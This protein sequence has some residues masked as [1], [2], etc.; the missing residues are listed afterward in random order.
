VLHGYVLRLLHER[1]SYQFSNRKRLVTK[2]DRLDAMTIANILLSREAQVGYVAQA[3]VYSYWV[4]VHLQ[5]Q[6]SQEAATYKKEIHGL[7]VVLFPE[8]IQIFTDPFLPGALEVLKAYPS[9]SEIAAAGDEAIIH[10]LEISTQPPTDYDR[11]RIHKL[12]ELAR[13]AVSSGRT[14][15]GQSLRLRF[16]C[17]QLEHTQY[18]FAHLQTEIEQLLI[19]DPQVKG[20]KQI[21]KFGFKT[22]AASHIGWDDVQHKV[23]ADNVITHPNSLSKITIDQERANLFGTT[24][25]EHKLWI[26]YIFDWFGA[27]LEMRLRRYLVGMGIATTVWG[28]GFILSLIIGF[29][30]EYLNTKAVYFFWIGIAWC[31]NALRWLSQVYHIR[32]N[33]VRPCFPVDDAIYKSTVSPF[34][35]KAVRNKR[36]FFSSTILVIPILIYFGAIM[37]GYIKP[38]SSLALGFPSSFPKYWLTGDFLL[39]KWAIIALLLWVAFVEVFTG[40]QLT[41]STAPL[42]DKLSTLPVLPLPSLVSDL[43]QGILNLYLTGALMWS[44]GIV[45]V[46]LLYGTHA[47]VLGI[48]FVI[49]VIGLGVFAYLKPLEAIRRIWQNA[50]NEAIGDTL[51][52]VYTSNTYK[53]SE[54]LKGINEYIQSI[55]NSE[56]GKLNMVQFI[57]FVA[58]QILPIL[59]LITNSFSSGFNLINKINGG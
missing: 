43:F 20:L 52:D 28:L 30:N 14:V 13:R 26:D 42:Y 24:R 11:L 17:Y 3:R 40:A 47:N 45:L 21:P 46:E 54:K 51:F 53:D 48:G 44:F 27:T 1:Y 18:N 38:S 6:M 50:K 4:L 29:G 10:I 59:P 41:L 15:D 25:I 49:L 57:S 19:D 32:T 37:F 2:K 35:R 12:V 36:I 58:I 31:S 34:A 56:P 33:A 23:H 39:V 9:A 55:T 8:F 7:I 5:N 16:L 22:R